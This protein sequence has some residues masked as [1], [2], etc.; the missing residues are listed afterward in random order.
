M[1]V[2]SKLCLWDSRRAAAAALSASTPLSRA[3]RPETSLGD[4]K[5]EAP[6]L[7]GTEAGPDLPTGLRLQSCKIGTHPERPRPDGCPARPDL[8]SLRAQVVPA[9]ARPRTTPGC[10]D[11]RAS[12]VEM[13]N[14]LGLR[15]LWGAACPG[16]LRPVLCYQQFSNVR[17]AVSSPP[18]PTLPSLSNF[19]APRKFH[20]SGGQE[21]LLPHAAGL[22]AE[23]LGSRVGY[24]S[25]SFSFLSIFS[26]YLLLRL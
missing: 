6:R 22:L 12:G 10:P 14:W 20:N 24:V 7:P 3:R 19:F 15:F 16:E 18:L 2:C 17:S 21:G 11:P 26:P 13:W 8:A 9:G 5:A 4:V 1:G 23:C 25:V